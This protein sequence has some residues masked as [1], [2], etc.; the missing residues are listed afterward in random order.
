MTSDPAK[1][2][3]K[4]ARPSPGTFAISVTPRDRFG[5]YLGPGYASAVNATLKGAGKIAG[6]AD[7]DQT[8]RHVRLHRDRRA[9]RRD[10]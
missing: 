10:A 3:I 8:G 6:P 4:T 2:L 1:T 5:N 7:R 9:G